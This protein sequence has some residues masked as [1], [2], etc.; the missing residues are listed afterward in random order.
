MKSKMSSWGAIREGPLG[1]LI[2]LH[3]SVNVRSIYFL[4]VCHLF[5]SSILDVRHKSM[6]FYLMNTLY[7]C[8]IGNRINVNGDPIGLANVDIILPWL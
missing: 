1:G 4:I 5:Q 7:F 3:L 8:L 2:R 6:T